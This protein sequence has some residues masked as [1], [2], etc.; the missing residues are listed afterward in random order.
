MKKFVLLLLF[1]V[2]LSFAQLNNLP[3]KQSGICKDFTILI[4]S[5]LQGC[6]DVK[7]DAP[8]H[9]ITGEGPRD[10]FFYANNAM[11]N[12]SAELKVKYS[13]SNDI[14]ARLKLR[15]NS[16]ILEKDFYVDQNCPAE[17]S[18]EMVFVAAIIIIL[19]L[20]GAAA[21]YVKIK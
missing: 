5:D 4:N 12:G 7:I 11:C 10:M 6:W 9:I 19:I 8:G 20:L 13:T 3:I 2:P 1:L 21:W 17:L 18:A 14:N 15:Q 16:T